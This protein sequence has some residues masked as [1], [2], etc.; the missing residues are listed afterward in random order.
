MNHE[1]VR[2]L[3][4]YLRLDTTNPPGNEEKGV[5]FFEEIFKLEGGGYSATDGL[6]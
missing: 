6:P 5:C 4:Q 1:E 3:S 2:L